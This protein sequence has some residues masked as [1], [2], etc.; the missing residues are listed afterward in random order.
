[1]FDK[2]FERAEQKINELKNNNN[3]QRCIFIYTIMHSIFRPLMPANQERAI[4]TPIL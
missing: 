2:Y 1:M 3:K 4:D